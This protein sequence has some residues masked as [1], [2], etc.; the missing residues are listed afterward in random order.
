MTDVKIAVM[1]VYLAR[2][3]MQHIGQGKDE[4]T[5]IMVVLLPYSMTTSLSYTNG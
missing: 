1:T 2:N 3:T 5:I 4:K